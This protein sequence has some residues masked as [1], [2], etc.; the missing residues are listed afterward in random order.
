[1]SDVL[2]RVQEQLR[3]YPLAKHYALARTDLEELVAVCAAAS[4]SKRTL[5]AVFMCG[6]ATALLLFNLLIILLR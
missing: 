5:V 4:V 2:T 3:V 1:M 6:F